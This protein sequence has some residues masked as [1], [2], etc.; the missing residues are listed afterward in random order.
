[1]FFIQKSWAVRDWKSNSMPCPSGS[2][3]RNIRPLLLLLRGGYQL[4]REAVY[5]RLGNDFEGLELDGTRR[6]QAGNEQQR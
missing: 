1:M 6:N 5:P 2:S 3:R 4:D